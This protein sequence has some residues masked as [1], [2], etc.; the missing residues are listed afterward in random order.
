MR[1]MEESRELWTI[2]PLPKDR[3]LGKVRRS[4]DQHCAHFVGLS[5]FCI[6]GSVD[7]R[8][9]PDLSPR[10][11]APGFAK[12]LSPESL[13]IPDRP[14]NNRL[15]SLSNLIGNPSVALLFLVPGIDETLRVYGSAEVFADPETCRELRVNERE[16]KVVLRIKVERVYFQCAKSLMRAQLW[17][18]QSKVDRSS[19]PPL[20]QILK[21]QLADEQ[22]AESQEEMLRRYSKDL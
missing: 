18:P 12:V 17:A 14:G 5:P 15:D 20:G 7:G 4:L 13:L 2:Y 22:P 10:G 3:A 1:R 21:E 11:G 8:G 9:R 19:F 16:L 6:L